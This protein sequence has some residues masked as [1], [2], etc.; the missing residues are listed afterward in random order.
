MSDKRRYRPCVRVIIVNDDKILLG[1]WMKGD[2]VV[3][4]T[5]PGGGIEE[6]DTVEETAIKEC[7]EEVGIL[8]TDVKQ[9]GLKVTYEKEFSNPERAKLYRGLEDT[10]CVATFKKTDTSVYNK[11][12]DALS[13]IWEK[14]SKA[15]DLILN[16]QNEFT[17]ATVNAIFKVSAEHMKININK[18]KLS[19]LSKW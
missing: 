8:I 7:L 12:D 11:E 9:L 10:W 3:N 17:P 6:G 4:Y 15:I 2:E 19:K 5:F 13:F 1:Y 14:P 18:N 16:K